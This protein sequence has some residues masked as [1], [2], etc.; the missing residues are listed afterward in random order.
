MKAA[1]IL[2]IARDRKVLT[3]KECEA[4]ELYDRAGWSY[5]KIALHL[6]VDR[7]TIQRRVQR[8]RGKLIDRL[9]KEE[10]A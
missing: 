5:G 8:A 1:E 6:N 3:E 4:W 7:S 10:A 9:S 2:V